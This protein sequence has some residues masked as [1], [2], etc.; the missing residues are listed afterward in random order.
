MRYQTFGTRTGL[1]VSELAFGAANFGTAWGMG[2]E[3]DDAKAM[4]TTYVDAGGT[5][6]DTADIY[7]FGQSETIL[8]DLLAGDRDQFVLA[9]KFAQ[10]DR[11]NAGVS[12][13]GNSRKVMTRAIEASL[14]R[15]RTDYLDL[16]WVH[17]PD[18]VTPIDEVI[19]T[20]DVLVKSG[21]ILHAGFSN[22][23][24]WRSA[25]AG[26]LTE[27]RGQGSNIIG[28][29]TE[30]SL[31]ERS[32]DRDLLPMAAALGFGV[33]QYSPLGGGLLTG[34]YRHS[35]EG[36]LTTLGAV[37][38]REDTDQKT[39]VIDVVLAV[40]EEIGRPPAQVA[41]AWELEHGRRSPATVVPIIGPRTPKQLDDYLSALEVTLDEEHYQRLTEV[42]APHLGAPHDEAAANADANRGRLGAD[43][44]VGR[45]VR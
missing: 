21:K 39:A 20:I 42:S 41:M 32:A 13:T 27:S 36:R 29:Q 9:S 19:E 24:A 35:D 3:F 34:K 5:F 40:A 15:L 2:A 30:Y 7:Q 1:R 17:W 26:A 8:G 31:V 25:Y 38:H 23:P 10:G 16:Y 18:F 28:I 12:A 43:F 6:I 11:P 44:V 22:F 45:P 37:I 14:R 4:F 33:V